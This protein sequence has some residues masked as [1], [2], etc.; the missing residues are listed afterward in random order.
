MVN[1]ALGSAGLTVRLDN[2]KGLFQETVLW[3]HDFQTFK[4]CLQKFSVIKII[5]TIYITNTTTSHVLKALL[6]QKG[7]KVFNSQTERR[8]VR[9]ALSKPRQ[10]EK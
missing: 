1:V 3:F 9:C 10:D 6:I 5:Q 2:P 7:E 8:N 4:H